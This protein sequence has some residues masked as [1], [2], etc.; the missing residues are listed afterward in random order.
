M[1]QYGNQPDFGTF[2]VNLTPS[3]TIDATTNLDSAC[4]Y[5]SG[6]GSTATIKCIL[7]GVTGVQG[8]VTSA[9]LL[10]AGTGYAVAAGLA[11]TSASGLGS[12]MTVDITRVLESTG[13]ATI[14][15][16]TPGTGYRQGDVVTVVQGGGSNGQF[17]INVIDS[18]PTATD[19]VIFVGYPTGS[20]LPV[21]VDYVLATGTTGTSNLLAIK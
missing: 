6:A 10:G 16:A 21:I 14:T 9:N 2:A 5:V 18:L 13:I 20:F 7:S 15:I 8:V 17:R 19:A 12:G 11:V 4:I 3:D 1:G